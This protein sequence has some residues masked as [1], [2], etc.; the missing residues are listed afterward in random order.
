MGIIR[1]IACLLLGMAPADNLYAIEL[2]GFAR[3]N[4]TF[5]DYL[6]GQ[7]YSHADISFDALQFSLKPPLANDCSLLGSYF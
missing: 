1:I 2:G 3:G 5:L 4:I 6:D 7:P